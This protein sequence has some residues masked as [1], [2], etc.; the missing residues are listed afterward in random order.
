M[1]C[2]AACVKMFFPRIALA[3]GFLTS[4]V[5]VG[6]RRVLRLHAWG[7]VALERVAVVWCLF[8][9]DGEVSRRVPLWGLPVC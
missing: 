6:V 2:H 8:A 3:I 5:G 1:A 4:K 7:G 9:D